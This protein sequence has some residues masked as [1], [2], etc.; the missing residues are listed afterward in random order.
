M[1][2]ASR[3]GT[4]EQRREKVMN[5]KIPMA[6]PNLGKQQLPFDITQAIGQSCQCGSD[7]F[8]KVLR[9]KS[10]SKLAPGNTSGQDVMIEFAAYVCWK[11]GTELGKEAEIRG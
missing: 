9:L 7:L 6:V 8:E 4:F 2:E 3:R 10:V 1:G 5:N 11:C